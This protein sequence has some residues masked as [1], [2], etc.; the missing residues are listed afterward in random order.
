MKSRVLVCVGLALLATGFVASGSAFG[1]E[2][3]PSVGRD[4]RDWANRSSRVSQPNG[5]AEAPP[6]VT[7][8][9]SSTFNSTTHTGLTAPAADYD[10]ATN[11]M[12]VFGGY[13]WGLGGAD[14]NAVLLYAPANGAGNWTTLIANGSAGAPAARDRHSAVYDSA[15]NRMIV[16]GGEI[17]SSSTD[18]NDVWVLSNANGQ[19]G[20]ASW[21]QLSPSGPLPP[22]RAAHKAMYDATNNRMIV[23]GGGAGGNFTQVF[24]DVWVLSNANGLG[25]TPAWT[26]LSPGG[27]GPNVLFTSAVYDST[28]NIMAVFG[29]STP[30]G[31]SNGVWTLAH[32]NGLGGTPHWTNIVAN[33]APG[34]PAR[35]SGHTAVYDTANNRMIVFG[36]QPA[37]GPYMWIGFN[38][39]WVLTN[40]NGLGGLPVWTRLNISGPA[41][42][43]R[44]EHVAVYDQVNNRMMVC[45]GNNLDAAFFASWTLT[46]AN[47]L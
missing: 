31:A 32:A 20:A 7:A 43:T 4:L 26:K 30:T 9:W 24:H 1:Q 25:G 34:S 2:S 40:A 36:G 14:T 6:P 27:V 3:A 41:P 39:V 10:P 13:D 19:G 16:F 8:Q 47:G 18:L 44:F 12:M 15:N 29:G 33:G 5:E 42:G 17:F 28:N 23:F 37:S 35:R 21:T 46:H 45:G 11:T 22:A 38:D